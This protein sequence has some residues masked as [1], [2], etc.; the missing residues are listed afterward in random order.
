[1]KVYTSKSIFWAS[2]L[3][4]PL[5]TGI[6]LYENLTFFKKDVQARIILFLSLIV[7]LLL[8]AIPLFFRVEFIPSF[9][10][11]LF[12]V[13]FGING[14]V[15]T[16]VLI[17]DSLEKIRKKGMEFHTGKKAIIFGF[18]G[19]LQLFVI[20]YGIHIVKD[21]F[22]MNVMYFG[23]APHELYYQDGMSDELVKVFGNSLEL[24]GYF[25]G[26]EPRYGELA[27]MDNSLV[28]FLPIPNEFWEEESTLVELRSFRLFLEKNVLGKK[29][30][31]FM[32]DYI[33]HNRFEKLVE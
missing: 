15:L 2:F 27:I 4:G 18:A 25:E 30:Q 8:L 20:G 33:D 29:V 12:P 13:V 16:E 1:M 24:L 14:F 11:F 32:F 21:E 19:F 7:N 5:A 26:D 28:L 23:D 9:L 3:G 10:F 17:G 22:T 31:I 6:L